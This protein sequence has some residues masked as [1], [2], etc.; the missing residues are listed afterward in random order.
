MGGEPMRSNRGKSFVL[1]IA[2][3]MLVNTMSALEVA[4]AADFYSGKTLTILVSSDAGGGYDVYARLL[5]RHISKYIPG[6]PT[7]V[8]QDE[9]G[10]GGLRAA[11]EIY[12]VAEKD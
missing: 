3:T 5:A 2:V 4:N 11:Q 8:V 9:P 10:A 7:I 6:S 1:F 12:S